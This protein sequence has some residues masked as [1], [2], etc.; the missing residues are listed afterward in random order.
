MTVP[1][2]FRLHHYT[3]YR[4]ALST[5]SLSTLCPLSVRSLPTLC[6]LSAHSLSALCP[7]SVR[8]LP[9]L[10]PLSAHSLSALCPPSVRSLWSPWLCVSKLSVFQNSPVFQYSPISLFL[11]RA[12]RGTQCPPARTHHKNSTRLLSVAHDTPSPTPPT[13][14]SPSMSA[15]GL[16]HRHRRHPRRTL[17]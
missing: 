10:C 4:Q 14:K 16:R 9:T 3:T 1:R 7:L 6:P 11:C 12:R 2:N 17:G 13:Q 8:S 15:Q 5:Y